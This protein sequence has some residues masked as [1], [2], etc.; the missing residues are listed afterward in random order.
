MQLPIAYNCQA[1]RFDEPAG[2]AIKILYGEKKE[3]LMVR[4]QHS[5]ALNQQTVRRRCRRTVCRLM[6]KPSHTAAA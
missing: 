1:M 4:F 3:I 6:A 2:R 5:H